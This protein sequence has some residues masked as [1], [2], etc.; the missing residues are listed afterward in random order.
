MRFART[1]LLLATLSVSALP[2][3]AQASQAAPSDNAATA[4]VDYAALRESLSAVSKNLE[5]DVN[6]QRAILKKNQ[7]LLKEAQRLDANN[8]KLLAEKQRLIQQN[9]ELEKQRAALAQAQ[10]QNQTPAG[11]DI[12]AKGAAPEAK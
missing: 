11:N 5:G 10:A 12:V 7:E 6:T 9:A 3:F 4:S 8:K 1:G 2:V